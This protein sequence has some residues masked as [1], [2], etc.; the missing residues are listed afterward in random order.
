M[1]RAS[2]GL[3]G[4]PVTWGTGLETNGL[5]SSLKLAWFVQHHSSPE[6]PDPAG[7]STMGWE[8]P[9]RFREGVSHR[10]GF[11]QVLMERAEIPISSQ[12]LFP[13]SLQD[14]LGAGPGKGITAL[15]EG[16]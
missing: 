6:V 16:K 8:A 7:V 1:R 4:V 5:F 10:S 14:S 12:R 3:G 15:Q 13:L 11:R 9:G 2:N